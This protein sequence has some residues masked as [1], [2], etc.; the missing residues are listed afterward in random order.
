[1]IWPLNI[2]DISMSLFLHMTLEVSQGCPAA[3]ATHKHKLLFR[4]GLKDE[5]FAGS[6]LNN[7][8]AYMH[9]IDTVCT[10][11]SQPCSYCY[12]ANRESADEQEDKEGSTYAWRKYHCDYLTEK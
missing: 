12:S 4:I 6:H 7:I 2:V 5:V 3:G 1:M 9:D 11:W 10:H 8:T